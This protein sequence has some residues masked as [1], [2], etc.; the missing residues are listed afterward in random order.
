MLSDIQDYFKKGGLS[1]KDRKNLMKDFVIF[2]KHSLRLTNT[3]SEEEIVIFANEMKPLMYSF[4]DELKKNTE[5]GDYIKLRMLMNKIFDFMRS[6]III[7][8]FDYFEI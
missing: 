6:K 3:I 5:I 4:I 1:K 2:N 7:P 8:D